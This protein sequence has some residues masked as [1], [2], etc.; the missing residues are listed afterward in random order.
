MSFE[1]TC[2]NICANGHLWSEDSM[3]ELYRFNDYVDAQ[4]VCPHCK[5][6]TEWTHTEDQTNGF[7]QDDPMNNGE[8]K[9]FVKSPEKME[10]VKIVSSIDGRIIRFGMEVVKRQTYNIPTTFGHRTPKKPQ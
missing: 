10:P 5:A 6:V 8:I 3:A 9:K 7:Q 1:G 4:E 2:H